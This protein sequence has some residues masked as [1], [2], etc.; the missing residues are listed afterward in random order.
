MNRTRTAARPSRATRR[1]STPRTARLALDAAENS[2]AGLCEE[3]AIQKSFALPE[4]LSDPLGAFLL[5]GDTGLE[6]VTSTM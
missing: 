6:P 1:C 4:G 2:H 5:V 3:E